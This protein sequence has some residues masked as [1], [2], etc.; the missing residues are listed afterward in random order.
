MAVH[1]Q[2]CNSYLARL[3]TQE[4]LACRQTSQAGITAISLAELH[5]ENDDET[6]ADE[7]D[8]EDHADG[9]DGEAVVRP[10][11]AGP[12]LHLLLPPLHYGELVG[13]Q[14]GAGGGGVGDTPPPSHVSGAVYWVTPGNTRSH[15]G[16]ELDHG[17]PSELERVKICLQRL[18]RVP[19]GDDSLKDGRV[20]GTTWNIFVGSNNSDTKQDVTESVDQKNV[21][22]VSPVHGHQLPHEHVVGRVRVQ[23]LKPHGKRIAHPGSGDVLPLLVRDPHLDVGRPQH[24][25]LSI[26]LVMQFLP[27]LH[28]LVDDAGVHVVEAADVDADVSTGDDLV[29]MLED[30]LGSNSA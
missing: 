5:T 21:A 18:G 24:E 17:A 16:S 12:A 15:H 8:G 26:A 30:D 13:Q 25:L 28:G 3:S 27:Q 20:C 6:L 7:E 10:V 1:T 2:F 23:D 14:D 9:V 22:G 11:A 4:P 29:V 19:D